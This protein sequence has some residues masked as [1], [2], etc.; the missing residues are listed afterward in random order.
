MNVKFDREPIYG[1]N[2]KYI[3]TKIKFFDDN[4]NSNF[5]DKVVPKGTYKCLSLIMVDSVVKVKKKFYP[6][7]LL[8]ES[9][10]G[11]KTRKIKSLIND[12]LEKVHL[13]SLIVNLMMILM[14]RFNLA[15]R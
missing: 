15:M 5:Q 3:K 11:P 9:K 4:V 2:D 6:E 1:D 12:D 7:T 10:Y 14:I 13:M 8:E